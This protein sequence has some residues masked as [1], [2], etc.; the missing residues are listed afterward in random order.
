MDSIQD[1]LD[2][3][4]TA[5]SGG[6]ICPLVQTVDGETYSLMRVPKNKYPPGTRLRVRGHWA[7][8]STC[9]QG[10]SIMVMQ[11]EETRD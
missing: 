7:E 11:I 8:A 10:Q 2:M 4:V 1:S 9:Q 5:I 6:I 3:V